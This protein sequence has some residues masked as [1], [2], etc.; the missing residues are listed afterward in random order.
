M[1]VVACSDRA[2][3]RLNDGQELTA[4]I[5]D[6]RDG[7]L[8]LSTDGARFAVPA[9]RVEKIS[10]PGKGLL[11]TGGILTG[12]GAMAIIG[13][14]A[15]DCD[16][17]ICDKSA[18]LIGGVV[19]AV[20][21]V[22]LGMYGADR[23][24]GSLSRAASLPDHER[25]ADWRPLDASISS[26]DDA[27]VEPHHPPTGAGWFLFGSSPEH[28]EQICTHAGYRWTQG[29]EEFKCSGGPVDRLPAQNVSLKFC[30]RGLCRIVLWIRA[31]SESDAAWLSAWGA[32]RR[33][34]ENA[35]GRR[36]VSRSETGRECS[37]RVRECVA[38]GR[39]RLE[40]AW[41]FRDGSSVRLV[42]SNHAILGP[43]IRIDYQSA[44]AED[45]DEGDEA[46]PPP[47]QTE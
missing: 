15:A 20:V 24:S 6:K 19:I 21:G 7:W 30:P 11:I 27:I 44:I 41:T 42:F 17:Y 35:H 29:D 43:V 47:E 25:T 46:A 10:H 16:G 1:L 32:S 22:A 8:L 28:N 39:L 37:H 12:V 26:D 13:S 31:A 40:E 36:E 23:Y 18:L 2:T 3:I 5:D 33:M 9:E 14:A 45:D 38:E 4:R 34:L